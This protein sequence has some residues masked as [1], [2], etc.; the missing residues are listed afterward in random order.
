MP[1]RRRTQ[2]RTLALQALCL[3][4]AVGED[5]ARQLND[6]LRDPV[7]YEDLEWTEAPG[8]EVLPFA[9]RL[10]EGVRSARA[11]CD[12]A[13]QRLAVHWRIER[14]TPVDRNILRLGVYELFE[15]RET[16]PQVVINEAI[17]LARHFGDAESPAFVNGILDA[18]HRELVGLEPGEIPAPRPAAPGATPASS[19]STSIDSQDENRDGTV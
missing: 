15:E 5:F 7:T 18:L 17:E 13:L 1:Q 8:R 12:E 4:D 11:R 6:F 3:F 9:R 10:C 14:M 2:A 19:T 16:P